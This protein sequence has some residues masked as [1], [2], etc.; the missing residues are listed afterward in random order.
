MISLHKCLKKLE[1]STLAA[2]GD[3]NAAK[4]SKRISLLQFNAVLKALRVRPGTSRAHNKLCFQTANV[5][6]FH[7]GR[8]WT[9]RTMACTVR[10]IKMPARRRPCAPC[11]RQ[12]ANT[13]RKWRMMSRALCSHPPPPLSPR[14][15]R[16]CVCF[17]PVCPSRLSH[18]PILRLPPTFPF[19]SPSPPVIQSHTAPYLLRGEGFP[20]PL[21]PSSPLPP[22][23][24]C[25]F[26]RLP[27]WLPVASQPQ[28]HLSSMSLALSH[29]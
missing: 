15:P 7:A 22:N 4:A 1:I 20:L 8:A 5:C 27:F 12:H 29:I 18:H 25:L 16:Q 26:A 9:G 23:A 10:R 3:L 21:L 17:A 28:S 19:Y 24:V 14:P 13:A 11:T 2:Q 6:T